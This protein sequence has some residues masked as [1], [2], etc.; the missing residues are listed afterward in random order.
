MS[1]QECEALL[2]EIKDELGESKQKI[3]N[4]YKETVDYINK[5]FDN[6]LDKIKGV[7]I[8]LVNDAFEKH[9]S[10]VEREIS[11][12][13]KC[14][15]KEFSDVRFYIQTI[16]EEIDLNLRKLRGNFN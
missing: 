5:A 4:Y 12:M 6:E 8:D 13:R 16:E 3:D 1:K 10:V 14:E 9:R 2:F 7:L 15:P 11:R